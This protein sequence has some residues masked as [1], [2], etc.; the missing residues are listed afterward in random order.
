MTRR[1]HEV[2]QVLRL[3]GEG[4]NDCEISRRRCISRLARTTKLRVFCDVRY[5]GIIASCAEAMETICPDK[6]AWVGAQ[7]SGC[8]VVTMYW[9][10]WPCLFPQHGPGRKH[11]RPIHLAD[12]QEEIVSRNHEAL[13]RGLVHS[14]GCRVVAND[15][16]VAS[17]RY[18]FDNLS[19][20]IKGIYCASLQALGI[21]WTRPSRTSPCIGRPTRQ[22][23]MSSSD[24]S[25]ERLLNWARARGTG[26]TE[27][28]R[29]PKPSL[30]V[31]FLGPPLDSPDLML[32]DNHKSGLP[33]ARRSA[34]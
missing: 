20:D 19:E 4:C 33:P 30:E 18:H 21:H 6:H 17:I 32:Q 12:W 34:R 7:V 9:N 22:E 16:G 8:R 2:D 29:S 25:A 14:D 13:I 3:V 15:R 10:H 1:N 27:T 11:Q 24:Q 5:P 28:W 23:W 31:R 26:V